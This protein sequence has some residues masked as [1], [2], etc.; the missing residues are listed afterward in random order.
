MQLLMGS[1][2][3]LRQ[4]RFEEPVCPWSV[5]TSEISL[6]IKISLHSAL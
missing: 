5:Y 2:F 3:L 1:V 4:G 6:N